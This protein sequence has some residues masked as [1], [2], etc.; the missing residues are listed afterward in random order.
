MND[1]D[2]KALALKYLGDTYPNQNHLHKDTE[3][4]F[5]NYMRCRSFRDFC[6][7]LKIGYELAKTEN[8]EQKNTN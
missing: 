4:S 8:N 7:G 2:I 3:K 6:S 1:E 5:E